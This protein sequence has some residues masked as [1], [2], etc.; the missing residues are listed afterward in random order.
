MPLL[1]MIVAKGAKL[2]WKD[3]YIIVSGVLTFVFLFILGFTR[4]IVTLKKWYLSCAETIGIGAISAG[5]GYGIG[6]ALG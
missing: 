6:R 1:P 4:S 2:P 5:V 3:T